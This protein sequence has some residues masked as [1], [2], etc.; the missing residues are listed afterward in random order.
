[1]A[2]KQEITKQDKEEAQVPEGVER[3]HNRKVYVPRAD[4]YE[5]DDALVLVLD[6]PG[7]DE[8]S[9]DLTLERNVLTLH[10]HVEPE[11]PEGYSLSYVEYAVGDYERAFTLSDEVDRG[12]IDAAVKNG[13]LIITLPKAGPSSQ[14]ISV[15]GQ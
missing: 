12:K 14:K 11:R 7:V 5:T 4:I 8:D 9:V 6:T 10:A 15:K 1:M 2:E 3:I 13:V